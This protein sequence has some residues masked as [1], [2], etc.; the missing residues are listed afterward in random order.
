MNHGIK[1]IDRV[2]FPDGDSRWK[3]GKVNDSSRFN[4]RAQE[5]DSDI[6]TE[7]VRIADSGIKYER[8]IIRDSSARNDRVNSYDSSIAVERDV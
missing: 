2:K 6:S 7:R 5:V 1:A 3:R 8:G 4:D